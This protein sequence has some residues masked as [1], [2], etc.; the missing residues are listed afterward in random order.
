MYQSLNSYLESSPA[1]AASFSTPAVIEQRCILATR[2]FVQERFLLTAEQMPEVENP[3]PTTHLGTLIESTIL[4]LLTERLSNFRD[5]ACLISTLFVTQDFFAKAKAVLGPE[6]FQDFV[7][8]INKDVSDDETIPYRVI[9]PLLPWLNAAWEFAFQEPLPHFDP[10]TLQFTD[11]APA[12]GKLFEAGQCAAD[13]F[14]IVHPLPQSAKD[15]E[16]VFQILQCDLSSLT[17]YDALP[18]ILNK[19]CE[20][21][22]MVFLM[23]LRKVVQDTVPEL[24]KRIGKLIDTMSP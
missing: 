7:D 9:G 15:I 21:S 6:Q 18:E 11:P 19:C 4:Q 23:T 8:R 1:L 20:V 22:L 17:D 12:S 5:T 24:H 10:Q 3:V 13:Y 16:F 2:R 14:H